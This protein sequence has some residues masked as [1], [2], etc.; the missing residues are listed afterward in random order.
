MHHCKESASGD[1]LLGFGVHEIAIKVK[2]KP[3]KVFI[4]IKDPADSC[5]VCH[6]DV[7]KIGI[8]INDHGFIVYADIKTNTCLVEWTCDF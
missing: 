3:C 8:V 7:N 5:A 6:G 2:H 4:S 1:I